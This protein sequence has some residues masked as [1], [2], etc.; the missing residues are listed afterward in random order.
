[1]NILHA[2]D[3]HLG[4]PVAA[5]DPA[6]ENIAAQARATG[7]ERLVE[8]SQQ[9]RAGLVLLAGDVFHSPTPPLSAVFALEK[10]LA[11]WGE[12]GARVAIAPGNHDPWL[13][14]GVWESWQPSEHVT[15]FAPAPGGMAL[16]ED[17]PWLAGAAHA[18]PAESRD[19]AAALPPPPGSR[20][21]LAVL[22]ANLASANAAGVHEPYAPAKLS[23][24]IAAPF[25]LW[26]LGHIHIGQELSAHPRVLYA[27][28]PQGAHLGETGPKGAW[29]H[30][31]EGASVSSEFVPL[32]LLEFYDLR[33]DDLARVASPAALVERVRAELPAVATARPCQR[34]L[35]LSLAGPSPLWE[36]LRAQGPEALASL[37]RSELGLA[38][39]VLGARA[40]GPA[41]DPAEL[42]ARD[43][44]L[45]RALSLLA[46]A[47]GDDEFL[48]E[49]TGEMGK[50]LHPD[51]ARLERAERVA[52]LRGLL[53]EARWLLVG[54]LH[55]GEA[56]GK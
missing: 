25:A 41:I 26:A 49:L 34:C 42:A 56:G 10:A 4:G 5:P 36:A 23:Q 20:P 15:I 14:G 13:P 33:L 40:L 53:P 45:G 37:L 48:A 6:L 31:L 9:R 2:A 22:H 46:R 38:G 16:G 39:L 55:P 17:G 3:L 30:R 54:G 19:L 11:A 52:R 27:G 21:G 8:L 12:M 28:T 1:M 18:S 47:E 29:L 51:Q 7:L 43:D 35:R 24:M 32:A 50:G 44:V